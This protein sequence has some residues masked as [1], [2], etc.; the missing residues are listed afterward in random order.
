MTTY[1]MVNSV[2]MDFCND[3]GVRGWRGTKQAG[4]AL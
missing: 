3:G 1:K 2:V 4:E